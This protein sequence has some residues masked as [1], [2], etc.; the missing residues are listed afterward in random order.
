MWKEIIGKTWRDRYVRAVEEYQ[1][2]N[3]EGEE[4]HHNLKEVSWS[5]VWYGQCKCMRNAGFPL[6]LK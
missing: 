3:A 2:Q 5:M 1:F 4:S 6:Y